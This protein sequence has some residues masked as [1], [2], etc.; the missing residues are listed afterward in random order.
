MANFR[1][2]KPRARTSRGYSNRAGKERF[3]K[4]HPAWMCW[5]PA[6]WDIVYHR[7]PTR[8]RAAAI[9]RKV[10]KGADADAVVWPVNKKPHNYY[11]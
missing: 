3:A 1:R 8:A 5:W 4:H 7:R 2:N 6:W 10:L 11:W 9:E